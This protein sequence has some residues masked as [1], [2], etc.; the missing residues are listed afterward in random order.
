MFLPLKRI[1]SASVADTLKNLFVLVRVSWGGGSQRFFRRKP[2][3]IRRCVRMFP[4]VCFAFL[5]NLHS[6]VC[7][8]SDASSSPCRAVRGSRKRPRSD[9]VDYIAEITAP[10]AQQED[11]GSIDG[12]LDVVPAPTALPSQVRLSALIISCYFI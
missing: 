2:Q 1:A 12:G 7:W 11:L 9:W 4:G 3:S 5:L 8:C 6:C 10:L